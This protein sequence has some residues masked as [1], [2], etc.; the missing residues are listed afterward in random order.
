ML[1]W[2]CSALRCVACVWCVNMIQRIDLFCYFR[3]FCRLVGIYPPPADPWQLFNT[4]NI[5]ILISMVN[6]I[7][8]SFWFFLFDA[9]SADEYSKSFYTSV[10]MLEMV[11]FFAVNLFKM[12]NI[13]Q[14]IRKFEDFIEMRK[15]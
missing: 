3:E 13:L 2:S 15:L 7:I 8:S 1:V 9:T 4:T 12:Q 5:S 6:V 10:A 14:L 11:A